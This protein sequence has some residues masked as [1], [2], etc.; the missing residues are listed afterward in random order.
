M[1]GTTRNVVSFSAWNFDSTDCGDYVYK[2]NT[3]VLRGE[4]Y[5][6]EIA[7]P[8]YHS[9][10][11]I[12]DSVTKYVQE[13]GTN[14]GVLHGF[15]LRDLLFSFGENLQKDV[16]VEFKQLWNGF[17]TWVYRSISSAGVDTNYSYSDGG[18]EILVGMPEVHKAGSIATREI[19]GTAQALI[20]NSLVT[21]GYI[22]H[23]VLSVR[24]MD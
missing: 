12:P 6:K 20:A 11:T 8:Y 14:T 15:T 3:N 21:T 7:V 16:V 10:D 2:N 22:M 9:G 18:S 19:Y 5:E 17:S 24:Y 4:S 1:L 13:D 23:G